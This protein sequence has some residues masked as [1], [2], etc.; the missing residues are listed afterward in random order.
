MIVPKTALIATT[1]NEQITVSFSAAIDWA[2]GDRVPEGAEAAT[3]RLGDHRGQRQHH[4]QGQVEDDEAPAE[5]DA[6]PGQADACPGCCATG[7]EG[8]RVTL[9]AQ[10]LVETPSSFSISATEPVSS[11]KNSSLTF[12]QPPNSAIVKRSSGVGNCFGSTRSGLT[13]R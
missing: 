12:S 8:C 1:I 10:P 2:A 5:A 13:G 7:C 6:E 4:H 3:G 9:H 11:S